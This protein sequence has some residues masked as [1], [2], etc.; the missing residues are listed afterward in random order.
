[1]SINFL[2][3][4]LYLSSCRLHGGILQSLIVY[5]LMLYVRLYTVKWKDDS[6]IMHWKKTWKKWPWPYWGTV[7]AFAWRPWGKPRK[8]QS[9]QPC[10]L[11]EIQ[12]QYFLNVNLQCHCYN[13]LLSPSYRPSSYHSFDNV[14]SMITYV[15]CYTDFCEISTV[16]YLIVTFLLVVCR[17][18]GQ[19]QLKVGCI[20]LVSLIGVLFCSNSNLLGHTVN[21]TLK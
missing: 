15:L 2:V 4:L 8:G 10:V 9:G 13:N 18:N 21:C 14:P 5:I 6:W 3:P 1:M 17:Y 7:L 12:T 20:F 19:S 16:Y 11:A